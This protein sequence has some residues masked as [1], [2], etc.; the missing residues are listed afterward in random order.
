MKQS[1]KSK[2][3]DTAAVMLVAIDVAAA[4]LVVAS[5]RDGKAEAVAT[6][7]NTP[8]GHR[9][10]IKHI[11]SRGASARVILEATGIYSLGL[12]LGLHGAQ[13]VEVM[14]INPRT[15]KD[16]Q[17]ACGTRAKTDRVDALGLLDYLERMPFVAWTA[18]PERVL[19]LQQLTRR[20]FQL[21][22]EV[23]REQARLHA[24]RFT[25]D[26]DQLIKHDLELNLAH[27]RRRIKALQTSAAKLVAEDNTLQALVARLS[28]TPGIAQLSAHR[29][30]AELLVLPADLKAPQWTAH[31]GLDPRPVESGSSVHKP[32][33]ITKTGNRYLRTA[34]FMPALVAIQRCPQI[35]AYYE[36][37]V[38][39]GKKR[40]QAVIAVMRK[41][42][43]AIWGMLRHQTNFN[44][45]LFY[46]SN[47]RNTQTNA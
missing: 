7:A 36:A 8:A 27:L 17:R 25:P 16:Y 47:P 40:K 32:R 39:R 45:D 4:S 30:L 18:P 22:A 12:A 21:K 38:A 14:V 11:T 44:A 26:E 13:R 46:T 3:S 37:L 10:L 43:H 20:I 19:T 1:S 42:L 29:L 41:M 34:L 2:S 9:G 33:R 28:T 5:K 31:A 15:S 6:Y 35:K 24:V 23:V